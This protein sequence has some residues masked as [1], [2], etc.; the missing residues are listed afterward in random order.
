MWFLFQI[1]SSVLYN[2]YYLKMETHAPESL[3]GISPDNLFKEM[4][5]ASSS[6]IQK[7]FLSF[8]K[9]LEK[10]EKKER[11]SDFDEVFRDQERHQKVHSK[12]TNE[13]G[14]LKTQFVKEFMESVDAMES[15]F[16]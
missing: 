14:D 6:I 3:Y 1:H 12:I 10:V 15:F 13:I 7:S 2:F 5:S 11:K 9:L 16:I 8:E 4:A